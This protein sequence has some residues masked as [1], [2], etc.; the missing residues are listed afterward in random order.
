MDACVRGY[1]GVAV[2]EEIGYGL[3]P[4]GPIKLQLDAGLP[5]PQTSSY[6]HVTI[7]GRTP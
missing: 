4:K 6:P 2:D 5:V 3:V 7:T 1:C